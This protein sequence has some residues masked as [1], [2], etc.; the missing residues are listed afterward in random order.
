M[1]AFD[2]VFLGIL[3]YAVVC[4]VW[5]AVMEPMLNISLVPFGVLLG[6]AAA[7]SFVL[8]GPKPADKR[9]NDGDPSDDSLKEKSDG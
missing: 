1:I 7:A 9:K 8:F 3:F 2:R 6:I 4:F 5:M